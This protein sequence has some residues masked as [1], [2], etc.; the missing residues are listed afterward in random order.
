MESLPV[1][2]RQAISSWLTPFE[3]AAYLRTHKGALANMSSCQLG[4]LDTWKQIFANEKWIQQVQSNGLHPV[5]LG[6][7]S[8]YKALVL[9]S[10]SVYDITEGTCPD[11]LLPSLRSQSFWRTRMEVEFPNFTLNIVQ[12]MEPGL[13]IDVPDP[14]RCLQNERSGVS[15]VYYNDPS[16]RTYVVEPHIVTPQISVIELPCFGGQNVWVFKRRYIE[17]YVRQRGLPRVLPSRSKR[18]ASAR[19]SLRPVKKAL[20]QPNRPEEDLSDIWEP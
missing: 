18:I 6:C 8:D 9:A 19:Q 20:V 14:A 10:D 1:E 13:T 16:S 3:K 7:G 5:L 17:P 4:H 2:L 12:I 15:A 11:T